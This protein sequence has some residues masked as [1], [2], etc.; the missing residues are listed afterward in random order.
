M[1]KRTTRKDFIGGFCAAGAL[2]AMRCAWGMESG[3]RTAEDVLAEVNA[4][5]EHEFIGAE[6]LL[7]DYVGDIPCAEDIAE[8]KPNAMG[9]WT[10][11]ENGSMFTGEWL[12]ALMAEGVE[13]RTLVE[14]CVAG[15]IKMSEVS[16]VPGFIARG[17]GKDGKSHYPLGSNDQT[18]PWFFG[19]LEY[20][21]WPFAN[22][23][24]RTRVIE[25]LVRHAMALEENGWGV[26][27]DGAFK[28]ENRGNLEARAMPF[29]GK[30]RLLY[31]LKSMYFLTGDAHW[32][33]LYGRIKADGIAEI[34]AGG[35]ID[36]KCFKPCFGD[37]AWIY[38]STAQMLARLIEMEDNALDRAR[39]RNGLAHYAAR[40]APSMELRAKYDNEMVRPFAYA[41]W[42]EGYNWRPQKTQK[43]AES[44]AF[45]PRHEVLGSRKDHERR[46]MAIPL[47]AAAICS[48][49]DAGRYKDEILATLR[50][51][52]YATPNISE[53]FH[54]AIAAAALKASNLAE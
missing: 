14:R 31:T 34:E 42:R 11:I 6:G 3:M 30:S 49:A 19:L 5:L 23:A 50:Y 4:R 10:P 18:D 22:P 21:R 9:W 13:R 16:D 51:C 32:N 25:R 47:A 39:M 17:T 33:E 48:L 46:F 40:V 7:L 15:L 2:C 43:D 35:E 44:V 26:P 20:C 12:P 41:N 38:V 45:S 54:A 24:I 36:V 27:C 8:L 29:W 53:F 52:D 28:G 37:G 1:R